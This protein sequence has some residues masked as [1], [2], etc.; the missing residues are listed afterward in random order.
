MNQISLEKSGTFTTVDNLRLDIVDPMVN[1][2]L[3]VKGD[4]AK[5]FAESCFA[6]DDPIFIQA[7]PPSWLD[8]LRR[9]IPNF[10]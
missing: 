4:E 9:F 6:E 3:V 5:I 1:S 7:S 8:L 2:W 10:K